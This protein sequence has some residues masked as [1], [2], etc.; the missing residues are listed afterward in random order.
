MIVVGFSVALPQYS[1]AGVQV[2]GEVERIAAIQQEEE[3]SPGLGWGG[4]LD[5]L[6]AV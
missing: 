3:A 6:T 1:E 5:L 2:S 4:N